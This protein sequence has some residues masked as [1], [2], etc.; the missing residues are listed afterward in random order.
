LTKIFF[1]DTVCD[2]TGHELYRVTRLSVVT[3]IVLASH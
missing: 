3:E 2:D 1:K